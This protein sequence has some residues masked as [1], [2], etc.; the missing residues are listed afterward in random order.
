MLDCITTSAP[1]LEY[2]GWCNPIN[3]SRKEPTMLIIGCDYHP[4]FQQ[5]AIFDPA[6]GE[7]VQRRLAHPQEAMEFY[8][9]LPA[10][11]LVG[12]ESTGSAGGSSAGWKPWG[13]RCGWAM[14]RRF[15]SR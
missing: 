14:P 5:V 1:R 2:I 6:T 9:G 12:I 8:R 7:I 10:G 11:V 4:G 3:G 15:G 13:T